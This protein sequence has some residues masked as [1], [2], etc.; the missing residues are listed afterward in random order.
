MEFQ[1]TTDASGTF[2]IDLPPGRLTAT[3]NCQVAGNLAVRIGGPAY[4]GDLVAN[5]G[6]S[7]ASR[8]GAVTDARTFQPIAG[9]AI[10]LGSGRAVT[11]PDGWYRIDFAY[12]YDP[13]NNSNTVL[14]YE[15]HPGYREFSRLVGRG[16]HGIHRLDMELQRP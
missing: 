9:V 3:I 16:I 4:R 14:I 11:G 8:Y 10:G 15:S 2:G 6:A 13:F 12:L 7:C 1:T 5:G